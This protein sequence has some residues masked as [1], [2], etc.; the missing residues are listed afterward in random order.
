MNA[1]LLLKCGPRLLTPEVPEEEMRRAM[2][3]AY[4]KEVATEAARKRHAAMHARQAFI[5]ADS[6]RTNFK[7]VNGLGQLVGRIDGETFFQ[8][9]VK[10]G[11]DCWSDPA[12][13]KAFLRDNPACRVT[14][15]YGTKGQEL[16]KP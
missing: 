6:N 11:D 12:F 14:T 3:N 2:A 8:M 7:S 13:M 4:F 1:D 5:A 10:Y 9:R 16:R 15:N